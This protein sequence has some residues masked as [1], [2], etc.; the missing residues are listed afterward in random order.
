MEIVSL[1]LLLPFFVLLAI[2]ASFQRR[3]LSK[4]WLVEEVAP[5]LIALARKLM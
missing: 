5:K 4:R 1:Y 2:N 3:M